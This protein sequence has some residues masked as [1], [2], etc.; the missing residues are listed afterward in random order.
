MKGE[1]IITE[2][3]PA[4]VGP[5]SQGVK[6]REFIFT[7]GQ[8]AIDPQTG[9]LVGG[10][11]EEQTRQVLENIRAI[12]EAVGSSLGNVVNVTAFIK[13]MDDFAAMN[14][15]YAQYFTEG[16]PTRCCVQVSKL[17]MDVKV[18]LEAVAVCGEK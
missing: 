12:L 11:I 9:R 15:V 5:Y 13:D 4:P 6:V 16:F 14:K 10:G 17:P 7:S 18:E 2:N 8:I 3:A 1:I